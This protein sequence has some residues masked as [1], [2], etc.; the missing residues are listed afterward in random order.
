VFEALVDIDGVP[1][2]REQ[3]GG[4]KPGE[5]WK[6]GDRHVSERPSRKV[7][8]IPGEVEGDERRPGRSYAAS[9]LLNQAREPL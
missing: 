4:S 1:Q 8:L 7:L 3:K 5:A 6:W 2:I 9:L